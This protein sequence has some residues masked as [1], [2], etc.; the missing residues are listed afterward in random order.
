MA[1]PEINGGRMT[2]SEV[3]ER[4][5]A[6]V[7]AALAAAGKHV[8][9]PFGQRRFDI[10]FEDDGRLIKV[11]CKTGVQKQGALW[12]KTHS[13]IHGSS[14]NYRDEIDYFGVYCHDR[15]EVYV[16][17]VSDVP[18]TA[19]HLRLHPPRNAQKARIRAAQPY[20]LWKDGVVVNPSAAQL[21]LHRHLSILTSVDAWPKLPG[22]APTEI[23]TIE[24]PTVVDCCVP[25]STPDISDADVEGAATLFK[26][27]G[28]PHRVRIVN[29]LATAS[30]AVCVCDIAAAIGLT[31]PTTTFHLKKLTAAGLLHREQR[32]VWAFY[33]I[34]A[35]AWQRLDTVVR[36]KEGA[37]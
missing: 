33:S 26:A 10:A 27:L 1:L 37:R 8:L 21:V 11:Q 19:A 34:D 6:A 16:V 22:M 23:A 31:Q 20:L 36:I 32:G 15:R 13:V 30:E 3:G 25:L 2:P 5:E 12:F 35:D 4:T 24:A 17:P 14:R 9:V 18:T 7:L 28:D 29:L